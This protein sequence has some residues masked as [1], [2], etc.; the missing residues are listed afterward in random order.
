MEAVRG[1]EPTRE[2]KAG[3][4]CGLVL[5]GSRNSE[6]RP[7]QRQFLSMPTALRVVCVAILCANSK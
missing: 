1:V 7:Q 3:L 6:T 4:L 5:L 2:K